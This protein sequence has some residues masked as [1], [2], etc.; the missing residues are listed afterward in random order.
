MGSGACGFLGRRGVAGLL[1]AVLL[2]AIMPTHLGAAGVEAGRGA[3]EPPP[4]VFVHGNG[5]SKA[6]WT[7]V[8]W[9]FEANGYP[10]HRLFAIDLERPTATDV[11]NVPQPGRST[12]EDVKGQLGA[13]VRRILRLTGAPKV[14]LVG[15]SRGAN[16][17]R[18]FLRRGGGAAMT[19][20]VV[21]GGGTNHGVVNS[22]VFLIGSELNGAAPFLRRLNAGP[23]EVVPGVPFLTLRSDRFDK[24]AQPDGRY[25]GFPGVPTGVGFDAPALNGATNLVLPGVDHRETSFSPQAFAATWRF[26]TGTAPRTLEVGPWK[27]A[28]LS[29]TITGVVGGVLHDNIGVPRATLRVYRV[30]PRTGARLGGPIF[31]TTTGAGGAWGPTQVDPRAFHEF[32]VEVPG[33]P[34]THIYRSPFPHSSALV[35]LRPAL[36]GDASAT[37]STVIMV[38]PRGYFGIQDTV[39]LD[40]A[41]PAGLPRDPVP[42]VESLRLELPAVPQR[43]VRARFNGERITVRT[44]PPGEV[45]FAEFHF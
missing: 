34:R 39:L 10:R 8:V 20:K 6:V 29:G 25:L 2:A 30:S 9:R 32:V 4:I 24:Y 38:R 22:T 45:A 27:R 13:F 3:G 26:V 41:R 17:I 43:A 42:N 21:L 15:N 7:T 40:G 37:R 1:V 11:Y 23:S 5:D 36:A 35:T 14:V 18:N 31:G 33:Q 16:T 12:A 44:W 28:A 19:A